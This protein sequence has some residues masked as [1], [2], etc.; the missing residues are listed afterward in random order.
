[1]KKNESQ[2]YLKQSPSQQGFIKEM[3][4]STDMISSLIHEYLLKKEYYKTLDSFQEEI[5]QKIRQKTYYKGSFLD[6]TE[7]NLLK[8][9]SLGRKIDF[10]KIWNRIIP[11][12][13]RLREP[14][15]QK[16]E[17]YI[18]VYFAIYPS[19]YRDSKINCNKTIQESMNEFKIFLEKKEY[20]ISK[21]TEFLSYYALP[22]VNNPQS[23]PSYMKLFS[24]E[25]ANEL[26]DKIKSSIKTYLPSIKY[27]VIYDL[28]TNDAGLINNNPNNSIISQNM[29]KTYL[30]SLSQ[31][32]FNNED[33]GNFNFNYNSNSNVNVNL[34]PNFNNMVEN[35]EL[36][37]LKDENERLKKKE[38]RNKNT[39][40]NSQKSWTN[41]AL[42]ILSYSFDLVMLCKSNKNYNEVLLKFD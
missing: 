19:L 2:N 15:I 30:E 11:N 17:F 7:S 41:L 13:I 9:F 26:K 38:E 21:T 42:N 37:Q 24:P 31:A 23:H 32:N 36:I 5:S 16:I 10:F 20:E 22:Y 8:T 29:M 6:I 35:D 18:Q 27:P 28:V 4:K 25:W 33:A 3:N 14:P 40:I 12:H 1:M 39:F 34:N